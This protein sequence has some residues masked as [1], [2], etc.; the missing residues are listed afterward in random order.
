M[1]HNAPVEAT[2]YRLMA[3]DRPAARRG[4]VSATQQMADAISRWRAG[5]RDESIPES[6][7]AG[8]RNTLE[9]QVKD[10]DVEL[11]KAILQHRFPAVARFRQLVDMPAHE[12][13]LRAAKRLGDVGHPGRTE[14]EADPARKA[15]LLA[16]RTAVDDA[17]NG[18]G[19][20][21]H[22]LASANA[23]DPALAAGFSRHVDLLV[24]KHTLEQDPNV[25]ALLALR[26]PN[27]PPPGGAARGRE[28]EDRVGDALAALCDAMNDASIDGGY[29]IVR[30]ANVPAALRPEHGKHVKGEIDFLLMHGDDVVVVGETKAGGAQ[31]VS[32]DG[33]KLANA[34]NAMAKRA[35]PDRTYA[36]SLGIDKRLAKEDAEKL[37]RQLDISGASLRRLA[38]SPAGGLQNAAPVWP[39]GARYFLPDAV[40]GI[41]LSQRAVAYL[42][43]RPAALAYAQALFE[44]EH[45][46][47]DGLQSVWQ[48]LIDQPKLAWIWE[49]RALAEQ[50]LH[51]VHGSASVAGFT[52]AI[53]EMKIRN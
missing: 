2:L 40:S 39:V 4:N 31:A 13:A 45:P 20:W 21:A 14:R 9:R 48:D 26:K 19:D 28:M 6:F 8:L 49:E 50:A 24:E 22:V 18:H 10:N 34:L 41:P 12:D 53:A 27:R 37:P 3:E 38:A 47:A 29:R 42:T 23:L 46:A 1:I 7:V 15:L 51:A 44:G 33:L 52:Q 25:V 17:R 35:Q 43:W 5:N 36:F 16:L 32:S 30:N 11:R